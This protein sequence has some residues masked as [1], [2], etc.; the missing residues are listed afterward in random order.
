[1]SKL[2]SSHY[3]KPHDNSQGS[4]C[5]SGYAGLATTAD[6]IYKFVPECEI[7]CEPLAGLARVAKFIKAKQMI[8][9]DL[10]DYAFNYLKINFPNAIIT[11]EQY[12]DCISKYDK[13][14][15]FFLIDPPY[16]TSLYA[17]NTKTFIDRTD[18][19]YFKELRDLLPQLKADFIMCSDSS[20][21]GARIFK[22]TKYYTRI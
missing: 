4:A 2:D 16:R 19:Q 14:G 20:R 17:V 6:Q 12:L 21:T 11:K 8:L 10:S 3:K 18:T 22:D 13:E 5:L 1:M 9:N 15:T 7:Y